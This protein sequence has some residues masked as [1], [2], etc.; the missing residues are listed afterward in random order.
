MCLRQVRSVF[1]RDEA[2]GVT[3]LTFLNNNNNN[4]ILIYSARS[5]KNALDSPYSKPPKTW[6]HSWLYYFW[7][8]GYD[9]GLL[10]KAAILDL[11]N[12]AATAGAQLGS[13]EK[14]ACYGHIYPG[15]KIGACRTI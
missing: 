2:F 14:L 3:W 12:M 13:Y 4:K 5:N 7:F 15:S 9:S 8:S 10:R 11:S 6:R 1:D